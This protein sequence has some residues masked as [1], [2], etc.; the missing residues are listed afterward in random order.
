MELS[1]TP[2]SLKPF[3]FFILGHFLSFTGSWMHTVAQNW[4]VYE[5]TGSSFYLGLLSF[6]S[7]T[8]IILLGL[9]GGVL[10]DKFNRKKLL[11][12][13]TFLSVFPPLI[14]GL[15]V[16]TYSVSFW[17]IALLAFLLNSLTAIDLPLRQVF[18]GE[19]VPSGLLTQA[20]SIQAFSFNL[21]R[22]IGPAL[23]GFII[24]YYSIYL[25][26][27]LN[28]LSF[29]PLLL[30][31]LFFIHLQDLDF[32]NK[33]SETFNFKKDL[34][35]IFL[36]LKNHPSILA[37]LLSISNFTFF[38]ISTLILL[39]VIVHKLY[40]GQ[41]KEFGILSSTIGIGAILGS[42]YIF[43]KKEI[44]QKLEHL[45]KASLLLGLSIGGIT[46]SPFWFLTLFLSTLIGFSFTNFFP[47]AN[48]YLQENTP[49]HLK[50]RI[51][52]LFSISF[53]GVSPLGNF[54]IG[55][56]GDILP[57]KMVLIAYT[58]LLIIFQ[59]FI[60]RLLRLRKYA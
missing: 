11:T 32:K 27:Y 8:P 24:S 50:G 40:G 51:M 31:L 1:K 36:F 56:L 3:Q 38:G 35:E 44:S 12:L 19:I 48:S 60:F 16:Q 54:I 18:I 20:L 9:L 37:T 34:K 59:F 57:L 53:L 29:V 13:I 21:A 33:P 5:L 39:P 26:F 25:C 15:L 45:L 41:A 30:F 47:I 43:L 55:I 7:S 28:A 4:L 6:F 17:Q 42:L 52:S 14:L 22:M 2:L 49:S 23:A 10:I 58:F 46:F